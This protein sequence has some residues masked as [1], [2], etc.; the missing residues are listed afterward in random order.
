MYYRAVDLDWVVL[1][2]LV[3]F[4]PVLARPG[5]QRRTRAAFLHPNEA[6]MYGLRLEARYRRF[7]GKQTKIA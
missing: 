6:A 5:R 4:W 1:G 3:V 2:A 7:C